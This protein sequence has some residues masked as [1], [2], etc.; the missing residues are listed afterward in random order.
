MFQGNEFAYIYTCLILAFVP[1]LCAGAGYGVVKL[2]NS[3]RRK[4]KIQQEH[5]KNTQYKGTFTPFI[6]Q[7]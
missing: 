7:I 3:R 2:Q 6:L 4:L 1:I 5:L